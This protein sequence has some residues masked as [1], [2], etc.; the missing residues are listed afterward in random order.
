MTTLAATAGAFGNVHAVL[1]TLLAALVLLG[2]RATVGTMHVVLTPRVLHVLDGAIG[3][4][5]VLFFVLAS[6]RFA[7][8]G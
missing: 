8:V 5:F 3:V 6:I 1:V 4:L 7:F 2:L